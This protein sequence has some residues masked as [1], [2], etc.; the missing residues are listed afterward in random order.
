MINL[1]CFAQKFMFYIKRKRLSA[2][3]MSSLLLLLYGF[4]QEA[5]VSQLSNGV[6]ETEWQ[7]LQSLV[8]SH[9]NFFY[10]NSNGILHLLDPRYLGKNMK[11]IDF[12]D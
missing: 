12:K 3:V 7:Y 9:H 4:I 11:D 1:I 5:Y 2:P 8:K 6:N 10:A